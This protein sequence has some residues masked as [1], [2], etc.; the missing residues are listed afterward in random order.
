M[1]QKTKIKLKMVKNKISQ[2]FIHAQIFD[3]FL[4]IWQFLKPK[5]LVHFSDLKIYFI[6]FW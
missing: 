4:R 5:A 1:Q 2:V 6:K 3:H